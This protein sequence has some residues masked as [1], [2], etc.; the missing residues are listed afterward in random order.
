[1]D[2]KHFAQDEQQFEILE[3]FIEAAVQ[4][5][6]TTLSLNNGKYDVKRAQK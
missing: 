5:I 3:N 2:V 4:G 6:A 1:M